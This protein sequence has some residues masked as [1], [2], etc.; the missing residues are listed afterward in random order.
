AVLGAATLAA[1]VVAVREASP[2][3]LNPTAGCEA[4]AAAGPWKAVFGTQRTTAA[5]VLLVRKAQVAGF[6][7]LAL[8]LA[9]PSQVEVDLFGI[10]EYGTGLDLVREARSA[11]FQVLIQPSRHLYCPVG[12]CRWVCVFG[13]QLAATAAMTLH[14]A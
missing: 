10:P 14:V 1:G 11:A 5:A 9:G 3:P 7:N 8:V 12:D 4:A 13:H 2:V 6:K